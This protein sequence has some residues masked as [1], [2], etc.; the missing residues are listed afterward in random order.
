VSNTDLIR[1]AVRAVIALEQLE[2]KSAKT[3]SVTRNIVRYLL[4]DLRLL[5]HNY[6]VNKETFDGYCE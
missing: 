4:Q 5:A 6:N 2:T 1:D 3:G